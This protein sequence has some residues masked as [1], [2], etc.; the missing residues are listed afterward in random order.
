VFAIFPALDSYVG[1]A[2]SMTPPLFV[3]AL[4]LA[5]PRFGLVALGVAIVWVSLV[6]LQPVQGNESR[7]FIATALATSA[8]FTVALVVTSLLR[9]IGVETS[10]RLLLRAAWRDLDAMAEGTGGLSRRAWA[11]RMMDRIG[12]LLPRL[13][14]T[15][16]M[17][18]VRAERLLDDLRIGASMLELRQASLEANPDVRSAIEQAVVPALDDFYAN[19]PAVH[20]ELGSTN[21]TVN[22]FTEDVD[23]ALRG[24]TVAQESLV[25]RRIGGFHFRTFAAPRYLARSG[26]PTTPDDLEQGGHGTVGLVSLHDGRPIPFAFRR[27]GGQIVIVPSHRLLVNDTNACLAAGLTGLGIIQVPSYAVQSHIDSGQL[28]PVLEDWDTP[29]T[30]VHLIYRPNRYLSAKVRV[31]IDW[32]VELF[33][34][35][36]N[37]RSR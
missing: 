3:I 30:P 34:R 9:V 19:Y 24:G 37:M 20:V 23:C 5:T 14:G 17:L 29:V 31:F 8:G 10:V 7:T 12:L 15:R 11:S 35:M 22:L 4:Y 28:V 16:G 36:D 6:A 1:L 32:L 18:R 13:A 25:A 26:R 2:L 33:D 27:D 21:R